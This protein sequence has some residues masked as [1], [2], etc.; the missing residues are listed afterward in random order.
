MVRNCREMGGAATHRRYAGGKK[1]VLARLGGALLLASLA[2]CPARSYT[3]AAGTGALYANRTQRPAHV[4]GAALGAGAAV[5]SA[6]RTTIRLSAPPVGLLDDALT[7]RVFAITRESNALYL[8]NLIVIDSTSGKIL[9][10]TPLVLTAAQAPG[11]ASSR[12]E[13]LMWCPGCMAV[14]ERTGHVFVVGATYVAPAGTPYVLMLDG[15][16]GH[17][18]AATTL[19]LTA[20]YADGIPVVL[21]GSTILVDTR[22]NRVFSTSSATNRLSL[23]DATTDKLLSTVVFPSLLS[24]NSPS[25]VQ[26]LGVDRHD[27]GVLVEADRKSVV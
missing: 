9:T 23:L 21:N 14:N 11:Q 7:R 1:S 3:V 10:T 8:S 19:G 22:T 27:G 18:L 17:V 26:P 12:V 15:S 25:I 6:V 4:A 24:P 20:S 2:W 13:M 16:T 5:A